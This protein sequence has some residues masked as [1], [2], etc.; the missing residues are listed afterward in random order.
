MIA[1]AE[2]IE[3]STKLD[4]AIIKSK[5]HITPEVTMFSKSFFVRGLIMLLFL[6]PI[7]PAHSQST[8]KAITFKAV[9][10]E[11]MKG[12]DFPGH[13]WVDFGSK[14]YG[15]GLDGFRDET[16]RRSEVDYS[17]KVDRV[18]YEAALKAANEFRGQ[19]YI[20][21]KRDCRSF[22]AAVAKAM[23]LRV[24]DFKATTPPALW[25]A[26]LANKD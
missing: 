8:S 13:V 12:N 23:G 6:T 17:F 14:A 24:P 15:F 26:D 1:S 25:L 19:L 3:Q 10:M 9:K 16:G 2:L 20:P 18:K 7:L 22:A 21:F 5:N 11:K 4:Y